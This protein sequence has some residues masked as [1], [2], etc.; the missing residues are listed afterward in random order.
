MDEIRRLCPDAILIEDCSHISIEYY[1]PNNFSDAAVFS[2][3]LHKPISS[4]GGGC[5]LVQ[6]DED[7]NR[8]KNIYNVLEF[9]TLFWNIR[10]LLSILVKNCVFVPI[11][12]KLLKKNAHRR[13][14]KQTVTSP[15]YMIRPKK[16]SSLLGFILRNQ[17]NFNFDHSY[18]LNYLLLNDRFRLKLTEKDALQ[19][20]YFP[21]FLGTIEDR[22]LFKE[23]LHSKQIDVH[24]LWENCFYNAGFY[25]DLTEAYSAT[26]DTVGR[27][28]FI[29]EAVFKD[30]QLVHMID[31]IL[32]SF[33]L[34]LSQ[35]K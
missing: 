4:G 9:P 5:L 31:G 25:A 28:V 34:H 35:F 3:N 24:V 29:P 18:R 26:S 16:M 21:L 17:I 10:K 11:I 7:F 2:F 20:C 27:I 15:H 30:E 12:Y 32:S 14:L 23:V 33:D 1:T 22:N 13:R 19:L 8:F 6:K